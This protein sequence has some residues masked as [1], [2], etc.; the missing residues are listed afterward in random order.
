MTDRSPDPAH[1][2]CDINVKIA[3]LGNACWE[4]C[5]TL[6]TDQVRRN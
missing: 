1:E 3:D 4:V 5:L 6:Y 2:N